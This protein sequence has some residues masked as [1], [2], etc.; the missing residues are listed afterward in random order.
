MT[1]VE[2]PKS[3]SVH[4][5]A[6]LSK[7]VTDDDIDALNALAED[8]N[9]RAVPNVHMSERQFVDWG[10][11]D[12]K[13]EWEDGDIILMT[14]ASALHGELNNWLLRLLG[15]FVEHHDSG[16][17]LGPEF[18]VRL[19]TLRR[20]RVPDVL[21]VSRSRQS[22]F[23]PNHLE[24]SPDLIMEIVSPDSTVRDWQTKFIEYQKA[25]VREYW[26]IDPLIKRAEAYSL[27][28]GEYR[29]V[30]PGKELQLP[31]KV[32]KG[33][34]LRPEWLWQTPLPKTA[35]VLKELGLR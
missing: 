22:L 5:K 26:V 23:R 11:E 29:S 16:T 31:S 14:T 12:V 1:L 28:R 21:F 19:G 15:E 24:G 30:K 2:L 4:R 17:L 34:Y 27:T 13:A 18:M 32:L 8:L 10:D 3:R 9:G 33:F 7:P 6:V 20:R 25:G 35:V